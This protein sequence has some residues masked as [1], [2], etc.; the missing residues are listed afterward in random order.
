MLFGFKRKKPQGLN[1]IRVSK[2]NLLYVYKG[3]DEDGDETVIGFDEVIKLPRRIYMPVA[4]LLHMLLDAI[5]RYLISG[6]IYSATSSIPGAW[7]LENYTAVSILAISKALTALKNSGFEIPTSDVQELLKGS[8]ALELNDRRDYFVLT[9]YPKND[10]PR[11]FKVLLIRNDVLWSDGT[12]KPE[13]S[14][15]RI[16]MANHW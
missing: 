15:M 16:E 8:N 4:Q 11:R 10:Q 13:I 5:R 14:N 2:D 9:Y 1:E 3:V 12:T 6:N 7:V